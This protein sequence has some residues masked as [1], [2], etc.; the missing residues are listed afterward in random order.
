MAIRNN[1]AASVVYGS[2]DEIA[3]GKL[4]M[5][6]FDYRVYDD[7]HKLSKKYKRSA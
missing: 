5:M 2:E 1:V 7:Y 4:N 6:G 3:L